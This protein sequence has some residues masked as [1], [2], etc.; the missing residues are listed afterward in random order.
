[1]SNANNTPGTGGTS[2]RSVVRTAAHAAWAV[3]VIQIAAAAPAFADSKVNGIE[4]PRTTLNV[5]RSPATVSNMTVDNDGPT[6]LAGSTVQ[7]LLTVSGGNNLALWSSP[8][9]TGLWAYATGVGTTTL[10]FTYTGPV[11]IGNDVSLTG[12]ASGTLP[13]NSGTVSAT[14]QYVGT[15]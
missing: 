2:R 10:V 13:N 8:T 12:T 15:P 3:P 5:S 9:S 1:M 11:A 7:L 4:D 6:A 14:L